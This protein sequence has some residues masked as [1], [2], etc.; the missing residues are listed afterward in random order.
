MKFL[1]IGNLSL[2]IFITV[3][4]LSIPATFKPWLKKKIASRPF[5]QP[6]SKTLFFLFFLYTYYNK[7]LKNSMVLH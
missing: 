5:P 3:A 7:T 2:L 6:T 1:L 4:D